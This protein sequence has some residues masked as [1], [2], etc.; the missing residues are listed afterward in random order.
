MR[1]RARLL[2]P[3]LLMSLV[4]N[5]AAQD[6]LFA[7]MAKLVGHELPSEPPRGEWKDGDLVDLRAYASGSATGHIMA[8]G[9]DPCVLVHLWIED[10][11]TDWA[12]IST[13]TYDF[14]KLTKA[15]FIGDE[16]DR[17]AAPSRSADDDAATEMLLEGTGWSVARFTRLDP[18]DP[19]Y[20]QDV[21]DSWS[22][23]VY[24]QQSRSAVAEAV[25][26][27]RAACFPPP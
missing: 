5:A 8:R 16:D 22:I 14:R 17:T 2:C 1:L 11:A 26:V 23:F 15:R 20:V 13:K 4:P 27:V 24:D 6:A 7:A 19:V 12:R 18:A 21:E 25:E 10:S 3:L 9:G